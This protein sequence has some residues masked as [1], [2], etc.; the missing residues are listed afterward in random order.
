ATDPHAK[1][2]AFAALPPHQHR[3]TASR[4]VSPTT[5]ND[6]HKITRAATI[7]VPKSPGASVAHARKP[8]GK[9]NTPSPPRTIAAHTGLGF[10]TPTRARTLAGH[11]LERDVPPSPASSSELSPVGQDMMH[12]LRMQR[13]RARQVE[14]RRGMWVRE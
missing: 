4:S 5:P 13:L 11:F 14:R 9:E 3:R 10:M 2:E 12:N 8:L 7:A 1:R 6:E